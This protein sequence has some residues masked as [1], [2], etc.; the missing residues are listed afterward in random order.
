VGTGWP[1]ANLL[2]SSN[3]SATE[4]VPKSQAAVSALVVKST[5]GIGTVP[6]GFGHTAI[7]FRY[8]SSCAPAALTVSKS[9]RINLWRSFTDSGTWLRVSP[10]TQEATCKVFE[11]VNGSNAT[12]SLNMLGGLVR[13]RAS[14]A[15]GLRRQ[16]FHFP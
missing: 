8:S 3:S 14:D 5:P 7:S 6:L 12:T 4:V 1:L 9:A 2:P 13:R 10:C 15:L 11:A 16:S